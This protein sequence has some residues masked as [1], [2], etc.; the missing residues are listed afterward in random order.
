MAIT[1]APDLNL[2][3]FNDV[4]VGAPLEGNGQGAVYIY[5]GDASKSIRKQSSQVRYSVCDGNKTLSV[6]L[7]KE[8]NQWWFGVMEQRNCF[9]P[10]VDY[11]SR[12]AH[13]QVFY[14]LHKS[15]LDVFPKFFSASIKAYIVY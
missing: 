2:D 5:N 14:S 6:E 15:Q 4:V 10:E 13:P 1:V 8:N 7:M 11:F 3:G 9:H 12:T